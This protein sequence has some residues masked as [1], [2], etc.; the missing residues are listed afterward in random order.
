MIYVPEKREAWIAKGN[1]CQTAF[2]KYI[3]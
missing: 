3:V 1:P 2:V